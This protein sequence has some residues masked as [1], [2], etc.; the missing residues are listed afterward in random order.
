MSTVSHLPPT[1]IKEFG[2]L[3]QSNFGVNLPPEEIAVRANDF[4]LLYAYFVT[5]KQGGY[6]D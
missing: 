2:E 4:L 1:A 5:G 6:H 3:F